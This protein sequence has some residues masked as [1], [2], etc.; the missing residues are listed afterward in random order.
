MLTDVIT[1]RIFKFFNQH[2][3]FWIILFSKFSKII[4]EQRLKFLFF[5]LKCRNHLLI[6]I[7]A[8]FIIT[9]LTLIL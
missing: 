9:H 1:C 6:V 2:L 5:F 8:V 3:I 4:F 7:I